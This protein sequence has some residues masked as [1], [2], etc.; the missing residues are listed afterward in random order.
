M[1]VIGGWR[2]WCSSLAKHPGDKVAGNRGTSANLPVG[3][4][5][6]RHTVALENGAPFPEALLSA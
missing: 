4:L 5:C 3:S 1:I 2:T 6:T